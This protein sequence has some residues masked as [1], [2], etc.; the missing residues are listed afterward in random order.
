MYH[1][2]LISVES[3]P[4]VGVPGVDMEVLLSLRCGGGIPISR[5]TAGRRLIDK[6]NGSWSRGNLA[7][8]EG[9]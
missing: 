6:T 8:T 2:E 4:G 1:S 3:I 9:E 7:T 5:R